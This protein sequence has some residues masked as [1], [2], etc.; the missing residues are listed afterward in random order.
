[1]AITPECDSGSLDSKIQ[2]PFRSHSRRPILRARSR[3]MLFLNL[4]TFLDVLQSFRLSE[5]FMPS[6]ETKVFLGH[7][8][9]VS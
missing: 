1:M 3:E 5:G 9:A 6:E 2:A 8:Y 7:L 4:Q